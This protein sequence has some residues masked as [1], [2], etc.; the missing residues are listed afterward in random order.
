MKDAYTTEPSQTVPN[1]SPVLARIRAMAPSMRPGEAKVARAV[2]E[3]PDEVVFWSVSELAEVAGTSTAT[4]V[5]CAQQLELRG[6]H[7][8]KLALARE[9]AGRPELA[10]EGADPASILAVVS[11][12]G[13]ETAKEAPTLIADEDFAAAVEIVNAAERLI[14][15]GVGT[16]SALASDAAYRFSIIGRP[17]EAPADAHAQHV[18]ASSLRKGDA[19]LVVSH[20]GSTRETLSVAQAARTAGA[21]TVAVTSYLRS[22]LTELANV[23]LT[24]G[25]R[26]MSFRLEAMASR[27][28]HMVVLDALLVAVAEGAPERTREALDRYG[29]VVAEHRL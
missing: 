28:A 2:L 23:S 18:A 15:C 4:V 22:P 14:V 25:S 21:S 20:T 1:D 9:L 17:A 5:R 13:A 7:D 16:S 19:C 26:E 8:L 27:V 11:A 24:A 29:D 12:V 10:P 6:F 3:H